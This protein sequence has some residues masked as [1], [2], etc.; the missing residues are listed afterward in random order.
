MIGKVYIF[1]IKKGTEKPGADSLLPPRK[2][3]EIQDSQG[4]EI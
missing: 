3:D 4:K 2:A 1:P